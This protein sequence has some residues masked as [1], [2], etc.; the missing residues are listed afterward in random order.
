MLMCSIAI[1]SPFASSVKVQKRAY[2]QIR[3]DVQYVDHAS[4]H[5][6]AVSRKAMKSN[7]KIRANNVTLFLAGDLM[8]GR[9]IDQILT[10][11]SL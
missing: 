1:S 3:I 5:G 4:L 9:G 10:H 11:R 8:T 7:A 2:A 6:R